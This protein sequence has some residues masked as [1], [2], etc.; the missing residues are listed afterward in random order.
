MNVS[1]HI[2][3]EIESALLQ[4]ASATGKDVATIVRDYVVERLAEDA[5]PPVTI[6]SHQEFTNRLRQVIAMHP[7]SNGTVDDSRE[8][9]Y[10]GRGE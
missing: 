8:S 6:G 1:I 3:A 4:R 10:A 2:P 9:I 5:P 7:I